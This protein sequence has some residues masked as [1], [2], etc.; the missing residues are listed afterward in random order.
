MYSFC[1]FESCPVPT[2]AFCPAY[3]FLSRQVMVWYSHL[4]KN[5][6]VFY[7]LHKG[8]SIVKEAEVDV[9]LEF[10]CFLHDPANVVNFI[11]GSS[12][13]SE[14]SLYIWKFFILVLLKPSLKD[15]GHNLARMWNDCNCM[16]VGTFFGIAFFGIWMKTDLFQSCGHCWVF[17]IF[18][19][20]ECSTLTAPSFRIYNS[21]AGIPSPPLS[22]FIVMLS[23]AH[24]T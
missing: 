3:R 12:A 7:D 18:W 1:D 6:P 24:F 8:F 15:F 13:F 19:D 22:L 10:L 14:P 2:V 17:Q 4:F 20:I 23:K 11:S 5:F 9:F 21:S 16:V